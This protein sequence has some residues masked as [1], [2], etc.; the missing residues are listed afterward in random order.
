MTRLISAAPVAAVLAAAGLVTGVASSSEPTAG[1]P[2][3]DVTAFADQWPAHNLDL[4]NT[5]ATTSSPI[6][7]TN[8][9]RLRPKWTFKLGGAGAFGAF[10]T[11]PLALGA[12]IYFQDLSSNVYALAARDGSVLWSAQAPAGVNAFAAIDGDTLLIGAGATS[13]SV[14]HPSHE[15]VAYSIGAGR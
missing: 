2:P 12:S 6:D 9:A 10:A 7:S 4:A 14:K 3:P 8:V 1:A 15:L 5:R 11:A 13:P